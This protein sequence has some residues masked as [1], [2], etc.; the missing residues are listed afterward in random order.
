MT[1]RPFTDKITDFSIDG[2]TYGILRQCRLCK[3]FRSLENYNMSKKG[4]KRQDRVNMCN[5][6]SS[7]KH[8]RSDNCPMGIRTY[9]QTP[10]FSSEDFLG[11]VEC[12]I[13]TKINTQDQ[14]FYGIYISE[15]KNHHFSDVRRLFY[16]DDTIYPIKGYNGRMYTSIPTEFMRRHLSIRILKSF[17]VDEIERVKIAIQA[18]NLI[19]FKKYIDDV[20][21]TR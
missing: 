18:H 3:R 17:P 2:V 4:I 5:V 1:D 15:I 9:L 14:K 7:I 13:G 21:K 10:Y 16:T 8:N 11:C 12:D 6:C 20:I 19:L